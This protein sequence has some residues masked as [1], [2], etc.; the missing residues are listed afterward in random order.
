MNKNKYRLDGSGINTS[1]A[2]KR[3]PV[4][5]EFWHSWRTFNPGTLVH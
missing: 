3:F 2:L 4:S 1:M 5:Q